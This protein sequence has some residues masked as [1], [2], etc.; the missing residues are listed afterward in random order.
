VQVEL[1]GG[2]GFRAHVVGEKVPAPPETVHATLPPGALGVPPLPGL[3]VT[4]TLQEV[5]AFK[6]SEAG[7]AGVQLIVVA[8]ARSVTVTAVAPVLAVCWVSPL[9]GAYRAVSVCVPTPVGKYVT[10]GGGH[11]V[12]LLPPAS[13]HVLPEVKEPVPLVVNVTVPRG[14]LVVPLAVSVTLTVQLTELLTTVLVG[15]QV[16]DVLVD[17]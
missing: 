12:G 4:V 15:E 13:V 7:G 6:G 9:P 16:I 10:A 14:G 1:E 8:V 11:E 5:D 17:L 3:S 2:V